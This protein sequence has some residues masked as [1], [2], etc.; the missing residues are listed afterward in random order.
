M[1]LDDRS[2]H[3]FCLPHQSPCQS[4]IVKLQRSSKH[5]QI[6]SKHWL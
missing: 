3:S 6:V 5:Q 2:K 4:L 1:K